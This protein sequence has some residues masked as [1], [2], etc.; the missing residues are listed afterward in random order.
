MRRSSKCQK[1]A[2]R[3]TPLR[4]H[5]GRSHEGTPPCS[6][7]V[8][9]PH[10]PGYPH[11]QC[12]EVADSPS[13]LPLMS[14]TL[15]CLPPPPYT[16]E[17][18]SR[19]RV[20]A[21]GD[22]GPGSPCGIPQDT[23]YVVDP[24]A[25][26]RSQTRQETLGSQ[27][28]CVCVRPLSTHFH[29]GPSHCGLAQQDMALQDE[30][31]SELHEQQLQHN[32]SQ[33]V[34]ME[35]ADIGDTLI[36]F[37]DGKGTLEGEVARQFHDGETLA[38]DSVPCSSIMQQEKTVSLEEDTWIDSSS[39]SLAQDDGTES[40]LSQIRHFN[41]SNLKKLEEP[42]QTS[43]C[44][45]ANSMASGRSHTSEALQTSVVHDCRL[46]SV[47]NHSPSPCDGRESLLSQIR[48]FN[49]TKLRKRSQSPESSVSDA[50]NQAPSQSGKT[51]CTPEEVCVRSE[52]DR[53]GEPE[54]ID[55]GS[56]FATLAKVMKSRAKV[57]HDTLTSADEFDS[58]SSFD[59]SDVEWEL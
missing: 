54:S 24:Q 26:Q 58:D 5:N 3:P 15:D 46:S 42:L 41:K 32:H 50:H 14:L 9:Q 18:P 12:K 52:D 8:K 38:Q 49:K 10:L 44:E 40:F 45:E 17:V 56:L 11:S 13:Q 57:M 19:H 43:A 31:Q 37:S 21:K 6:S 28:P 35:I 7:L 20:L 30:V 34:V 48:Q 2:V 22:E 25:T 59:D 51:P 39:T 55:A 1:G 27:V 29:Q 4:T 16:P 53:D 47:M 36:P 23:T 33:G